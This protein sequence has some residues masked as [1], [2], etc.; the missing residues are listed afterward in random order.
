MGLRR[1][2]KGAS[3]HLPYTPWILL[4]AHTD[5]NTLS[6]KMQMEIIFADDGF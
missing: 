5:T 4:Q 6:V 3:W 2:D 1:D